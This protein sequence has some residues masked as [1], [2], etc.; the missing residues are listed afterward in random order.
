MRS[1]INH[2]EEGKDR[3]EAASHNTQRG[4]PPWQT[5]LSSFHSQHVGGSLASVTSFH[6]DL[7]EEVCIPQPW[8]IELLSQG[9]VTF[10]LSLAT[11]V[12]DAWYTCPGA[13]IH[14]GVLE[15][16]LGPLIYYIVFITESYTQFL[17]G[18]F[19]AGTPLLVLA[20]RPSPGHFRQVLF[21]NPL[22][23]LWTA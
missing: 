4:S 10:W 21:P 8:E 6:K 18:G 20:L 15:I 11:K 9:S 14:S 16:E 12:Q 22:L 17:S 13:S 1:K 2:R 5:S 3:K 19:Q 7:E 23:L